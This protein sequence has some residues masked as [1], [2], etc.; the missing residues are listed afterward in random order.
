[1]VLFG[2]PG[3][4]RWIARLN[5]KLPVEWT[6]ETVTLGR[7]RFPAAS[8]FPALIYPSPINPSHYVVLNTGLT[9]SDQDYN[10]DYAMPRFGDMAVLKVKDPSEPPEIA[11]GGLFDE[12]W[13]VVKSK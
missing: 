11:W 5:G 4:N 7:E 12:S 10:G 2:D 9:I 13:Q 8:H 1:V 3:S 6:R